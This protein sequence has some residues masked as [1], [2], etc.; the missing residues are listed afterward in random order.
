MHAML[1]NK[2]KSTGSH[3]KQSIQ[4]DRRIFVRFCNTWKQEW[5]RRGDV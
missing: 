1:H 5:H 4:F 3:C 2:Q